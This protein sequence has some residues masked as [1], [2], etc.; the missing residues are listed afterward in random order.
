MRWKDLK[1]N[2]KFFVGF[3]LVLAMMLGVGLWSISGISDIVSNASEVIDGN[4]LKGEMVQRE[5]DH[6]NWA[7]EVNSLLTD[8]HVTELT[9]QTDPH[10]CAFGKWYYGEGR[11]QAEELVPE[12]RALLAEIE[13]YHNELH[14]SAKRIGDTFRQADVTLPKFLAEKEVDHLVWANTIL[15]YFSS[16]QNELSVQENPELCGLGKFL[17]GVQGK[18]VAKS[19]PELAHLL[20]AIKEPHARLHQSAKQIKQLPKKAAQEVFEKETL[21]ALKETQAILSKI[22]DRADERVS[23]M[24]AAKKIYAT[25]TVP[26]LKQVQKILG[27]VSHTTDEHIMTDEEMLLAASNTRQGV[28]WS[29]TAAF[30]IAILLAFVIARGIIGPLQKGIAFAQEIAQGNLEAT[31]DVE[32]KDEVGK[33]ADALREMIEKLKTIVGDVRAASNNVASGSQELSASSEEMSQ[34]ATEQAAAAE[35]ASSSMEEMAAN[36]KQNADNAMQTEK[37]A[38]KSSQDAQGGGKAV[39]ETV[40]AMKDIAEKISIIEEIAR[41]TNLLALNAA[42]EAARAGEH[43]KGFAVVA[44]EVRKLAERSQSAAAEISDL[45]SSSV[46]VAETAGEM[47]AKM[48]PDIQRTAELV[49]EIAAAS[50]EQDTGADQVNK[51]I[52]QLDQVIQQNAAAAEEMASTSEELNAQAAQLQDTISFFKLDSAGAKQL[53]SPK[54]PPKAPKLKETLPG[55]KVAAASPGNSGLMLDM[56]AGKDSLDSEFEEY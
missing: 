33:M 47:L 50:K 28:I 54:A 2:G 15:K 44:S 21:V 45:S 4:K 29:L 48:V 38:L 7:N 19:D 1:L 16:E 22:K 3:G 9:V 32:Q 25:E 43:G 24:N 30:P 53:N 40:K 12:L 13:Q 10:K 46:E 34:G 17:Y 36:I 5:V 52:Q 35:E 49:Q 39:E 56:G 31:I 27:E 37:I 26:N 6:L 55:K 41:Q 18:E 42:I 51:A 20:E 14:H 8:D 11:K 23:S